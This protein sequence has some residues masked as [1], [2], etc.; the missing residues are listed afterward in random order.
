MFEPIVSLTTIGNASTAA[1]KYTVI[2]GYSGVYW[3][4]VLLGVPAALVPICKLFLS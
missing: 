3:K 1:G 4:Y 2:N